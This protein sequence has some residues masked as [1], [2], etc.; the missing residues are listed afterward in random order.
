MD[1]L[2][3]Q[4]AGMGQLH[5]D[6]PAPFPCL[7]RAWIDSAGYAVLPKSMV[8]SMGATNPAFKR[9]RAI[10]GRDA[11]MAIVQDVPV[12]APCSCR[13]PAYSDRECC[14]QGRGGHPVTVRV[15][16]FSR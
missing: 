10:I 6:Q 8:R 14:F 11:T 9:T 4:N 1:V 5:G 7:A 15:D 16:S 12:E 13:L 3:C 2:S